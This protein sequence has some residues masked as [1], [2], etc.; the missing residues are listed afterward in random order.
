MARDKPSAVAVMTLLTAMR[1]EL[2]FFFGG[3][4][5]NWLSKKGCA[6]WNSFDCDH[7]SVRHAEDSGAVRG[8]AFGVAKQLG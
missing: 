2:T 1:V 5:D 7:R 8:A 6:L 4:V 3:D